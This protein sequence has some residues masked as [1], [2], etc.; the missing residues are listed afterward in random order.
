MKKCTYYLLFIASILSQGA[1]LCSLTG[2]S[3]NENEEV[4][5]GRFDESPFKWDY[6]FSST[7]EDQTFIGDKFISV[8]NRWMITPPNLYIGAAY[9]EKEFGTTFSPEITSARNPIDVIFEFTVPFTGTVKQEHGSIGYKTLLS[10]AL[11]STQYKEYMKNKVSPYEVRLTEIYSDQDILKAFPDNDKL[12]RLLLDEVEKDSSKKNTKSKLIGELRSNSFTV[13]MDFPTDKFFK[14]EEAKEENPVYIRS[15]TYGKVAY[16]V[17]ESNYSYK[18]T[19]D[20]I[21]SKFSLHNIVDNEKEIWEKLNITL[22]TISDNNQTAKV[23][24]APKDLE[25]FINRPFSE[26]LYGYPIYCQGAYTN[27]KNITEVDY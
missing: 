14:D 26:S 3:E 16:F 23:F 21:L 25:E 17:I 11:N 8:E 6:V 27:D 9:P 15:L 2:C 12:S 24:K 19:E 10:E 5:H 13:Y 18:E 20:A 1:A 22:F 4:P 7:N